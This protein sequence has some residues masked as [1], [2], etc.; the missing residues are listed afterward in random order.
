MRA[1][2]KLYTPILFQST[3]KNYEKHT[4]RCTEWQSNYPM[5]KNSA[6]KASRRHAHFKCKHAIINIW[7]GDLKGVGPPFQ[8]KIYTY[9]GKSSVKIDEYERK[10]NNT[11][12]FRNEAGTFDNAY[13]SIIK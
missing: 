6:L 8:T 3:A 7:Q 10:E 5:R 4:D 13:K 2:K 11:K 9:A 12:L 1:V